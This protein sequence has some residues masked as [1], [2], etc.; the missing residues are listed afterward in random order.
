MRFLVTLLNVGAALTPIAASDLINW[1]LMT[2]LGSSEFQEIAIPSRPLL[3]RA[4]AG[5]W[6]TEEGPTVIAG[7]AWSWLDPIRLEAHQ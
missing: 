3:A 7:N 4:D 2:L 6:P 5:A 1:V